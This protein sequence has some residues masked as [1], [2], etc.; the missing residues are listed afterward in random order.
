MGP[1]YSG[2]VGSGGLVVE[3]RSWLQ[4]WL[5]WEHNGDICHLVSTYP[6]PDCPLLS[7]SSV[8]LEL[9]CSC[10]IGS[11]KELRPT[12]NHGF[13]FNLTADSHSSSVTSLC[14]F[15]RWMS[16]RARFHAWSNLLRK[17]RDP[18]GQWAE[19]YCQRTTGRALLSVRYLCQPLWLSNCTSD[20]VPFAL[21]FWVRCLSSTAFT[22][23]RL[24]GPF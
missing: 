23:S 24:F 9:D 15:P 13:V 17:F 10:S 7:N 3:Q 16:R 20:W 11:T 22:P 12:E 2:K 6:M 14:S 8:F 21:F 5:P 19:H 4:Q 1:K 18:W